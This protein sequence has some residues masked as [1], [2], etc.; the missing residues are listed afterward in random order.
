[1]AGLDDLRRRLRPLFFDADAN[2]APAA[3][4]LDGC[5]VLEGGN[6]SL[7]SRSCTEYNI[8]EH[9]FHKRNIGQDEANSSDKAYPCSYHDMHIFGS[10]GSGSSSVVQRAIFIPA[11]RIMALK[12]MNV[13]EKDK[14]EQIL[15]ELGTFSEACCYPGLVEFHGAFYAPNSGAICF[16]LEYMDGGSLADI[17][18]AKKFIPEPILAHMLQKVLPALCYLHEVKHIVHRDIK[19]ANL[20][21]NLKGD[22]KITDFG[23]TSGLQDSVGM[24]TSFIG[25]V[26]YM[27]PERIRNSHYSYSAD[28]WSLGLSILECATGRFPY[29]VNGGIS[30][31]M[32]Q[33]QLSESGTPCLLKIVRLRN[34]VSVS[35][36]S[37]EGAKEVPPATAH[38][39]MCPRAP[40]GRLGVEEA[41]V[42]VWHWAS[43]LTCAAGPDS[44]VENATVYCLPRGPILDDPSPTPPK[45]VYSSEFCSFI[46]ACLQKDADARPTCQQL[47]SHPFIKRYRRT[48]VDLS[49]YV[50]S[51]YEPTEIL[52]HLAHMLAVHYYLIFDGLGNIWR[53]MKTFYREESVF[54]FLGETHFGQSNIVA[55]LSRIRKILKGKRPRHK[56]VHVIDKVRCCAHGEEGV[57]IRVSG[58][59]IVGN[60]LL[61]CGDELRAE[62]MPSADEVPFNI[63]N[64]RIGHFRED[65]FMEPGTSIGCFIISRQKLSIFET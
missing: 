50:K 35:V 8:S 21:V 41:L 62:G 25:T 7:L 27:S 15:N 20:L 10:I 58:S 43:C 23:V 12:K 36:L 49:S 14:R 24:C 16:A 60:Q 61:V 55:T 44:R 65:F 5:E 46:S 30:N 2:G 63:M 19:P 34:S 6:I 22:A 40:A 39:V 59:F 4:P 26:T 45:D 52:R 51:V 57:A 32:L 11:H 47:L 1:M 64:K 54:S 9:G 18:R 53:H 42:A 48:G 31:L 17:I 3:G 29:D 56:L 13:F 38:Q 33:L 37:P 28:I